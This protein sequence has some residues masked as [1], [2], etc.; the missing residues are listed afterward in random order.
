ME[1]KL[2]KLRKLLGMEEQKKEPLSL[3]KDHKELQ[4]YFE[5]LTEERNRTIQEMERLKQENER[6]NNALWS[7]IKTYL[8]ESGIDVAAFDSEYELDSDVLYKYVDEV[9]KPVQNKDNILN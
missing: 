5:G 9:N 6:I 2:K 3:I 4:V 8:V 7:N 1:N